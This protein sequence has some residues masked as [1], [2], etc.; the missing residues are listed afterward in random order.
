MH[1]FVPYGTSLRLCGTIPKLP[2]LCLMTRIQAF[3]P[4]FAKTFAA[5]WAYSG[6]HAPFIK[7]RLLDIKQDGRSLFLSLIIQ[8]QIKGSAIR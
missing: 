5:F 4:A 3:I 2:I 1:T 6:Q 8:A 7:P